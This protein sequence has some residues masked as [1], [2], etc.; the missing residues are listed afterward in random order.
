MGFFCLLGASI[1]FSTAVSIHIL[2]SLL[3]YYT[4]CH[5]EFLLY[6]SQLNLDSVCLTKLLSL[7]MP[8][9]LPPPHLPLYVAP[10]SI[11]PLSQLLRIHSIHI[12][13]VATYVRC[14]KRLKTQE[15][16]SEQS[17]VSSSFMALLYLER[18]TWTLFF[19]YL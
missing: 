10:L 17:R 7:L 14:C 19:A 9:P 12:Y 4:T 6:T 1:P 5:S 13:W 16:R 2:K 15:L 3:Q 11:Q 18:V 8:S